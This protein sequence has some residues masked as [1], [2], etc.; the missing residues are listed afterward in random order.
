ME[1]YKEISSQ[2]TFL[3]LEKFF[4]VEIDLTKDPLRKCINVLLSVS[5]A[6]WLEWLGLHTGVLGSILGLY[7]RVLSVRSLGQAP[8]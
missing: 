4:H 1:G 5:V 7:H 6:E 8:M 2:D 3:F